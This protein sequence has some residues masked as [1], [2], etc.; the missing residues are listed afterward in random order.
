M[1][2]AQHY[3]A[4]TS[5]EVD[6]K[7]KVVPLRPDSTIPQPAH[8]DLRVEEMRQI[9]REAER[10]SAD[11]LSDERVIEDERAFKRRFGFVWPL[12]QRQALMQMKKEKQLTDPEIK[13]LRWSGNLKR[14]PFGVTMASAVWG[15]LWGCVLLS[16]FVLL[17][18]VLLIAG[19][20]NLHG[21]SL[22]ALR[23]GLAFATIG[24]L[25]YAIY[26]FHIEP[27]RIQRRVG[28]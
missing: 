7:P 22:S 24:L 28:R 27:W 6:D 21:G 9:F 25:C 18:F 5:H 4:S 19:W 16:Y 13:L 2:T 10:T 3:E 1:K 23:A 14:T 26:W 11:E 15:A 20:P 12:S 8:R 17:F